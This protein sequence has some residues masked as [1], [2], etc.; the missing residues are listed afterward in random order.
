MK[1]VKM[2]LAAFALM[3]SVGVASASSNIKAFFTC[4]TGMNGTGTTV[5]STTCNGTNQFCCYTINNT[6]LLKL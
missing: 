6:Q 4:Y 2:S 5:D 1:K 3:L